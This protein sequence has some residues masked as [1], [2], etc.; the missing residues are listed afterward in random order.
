MNAL[1]TSIV[2]RAPEVAEGAFSFKVFGLD[3]D[4][5]LVRADVF[6]RQMSQ[7]FRL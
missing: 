4:N 7:L 6:A 3:R 5:G 1:P 2:Q